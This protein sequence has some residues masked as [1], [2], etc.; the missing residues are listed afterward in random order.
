[1]PREAINV[2]ASIIADVSAGIYRSPAGA[3][4]EL[5]SNAFDADA[6]AIRITTGWP[7]FKTFTAT[8]DGSGMTA[9]EFRRIMGHIGGSSKRDAGELTPKFRRPLIGRIG[10]GLLSIAQIC[11]RFTV[12]SS[13]KG[14][15]RKFRATIDLEPFLLAEARRKQLG[16]TVETEQG[17]IHIGDF[18]LDES[19]DESDKRYT[20]IIMEKVDPGFR[21]R[22]LDV[23]Q[24]R[25][26][27]RPSKFV[28]GTIEDFLKVVSRGTVAEHGAYAQLVW[29]L[30]T[31]APVRYFESGPILDNDGLDDLRARLEGY[32]F[33]AFI[34]GVELRKPI[35]LPGGGKNIGH[36]V[37][38]IRYEGALSDRRKLSIRG[39]LYWQRG[40]ILPRELQGVLVRTRNVG[41]GQY[42]LTYLGYPHH[43]GWKFSQMTGELYVDEGL[44]EALNIDRASFRESD[45][46]YVELQGY[47]FE[48]LGGGTDEGAGIFTDIK[49]EAKLIRTR[50]VS[51]EARRRDRVVQRMTKGRARSLEP[52]IIR[53]GSIQSGVF[54][55]GGV[56]RADS[57][58]LDRI[59]NRHEQLFLAVCSVI[60]SQLAQ[61][62]SPDR[63]QRL[64]EKLADLF[65]QF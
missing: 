41:V 2:A 8:D 17:K 25:G 56:I 3:I 21:T 42:D 49:K 45:A 31:M 40:R 16:Y 65:S 36:K 10:I 19:D 37:Y 20:R 58:L 52:D 14:T 43:E 59:P 57:R 1:M 26:G 24:E 39:Y 33:K 22:L 23:P 28:E 34:D 50:E 48:K 5:I 15:P 60:E 63:R 55:Q 32:R 35:L 54:L 30:A 29:E 44:E 13:A 27:F 62:L 7:N 51:K 38:Q 53:D 64:Y 46:G 12:I 4:K 11:R 18:E 9:D 61:S 6:S 47:L